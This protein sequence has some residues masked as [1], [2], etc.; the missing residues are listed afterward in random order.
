MALELVKGDVCS[1]IV[2]QY[3]HLSLSF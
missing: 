3:A 2:K 1:H